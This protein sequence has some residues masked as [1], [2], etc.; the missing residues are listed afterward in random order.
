[1]A[2]L[3]RHFSNGYTWD[4]GFIIFQVGDGEEFMGYLPNMLVGFGHKPG[5]RVMDKRS[6]INRTYRDPIPGTEK[7]YLDIVAGRV[8]YR[9]R[10]APML[11]LPSPTRH[12][13]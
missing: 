1:M 8:A 11:G 7:H 9:P 13:N 4:S 6:I 12:Q 2:T 10:H 5:V 3:E